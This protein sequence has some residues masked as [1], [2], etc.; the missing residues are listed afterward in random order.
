MVDRGVPGGDGIFVEA[1]MNETFVDECFEPRVGI[2]TG[3]GPAEI[4]R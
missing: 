2:G 1:E 3:H 4:F